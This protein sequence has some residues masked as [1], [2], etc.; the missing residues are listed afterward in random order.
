VVCSRKLKEIDLLEKG[1]YFTPLY[2]QSEDIPNSCGGEG[3]AGSP[4]SQ[5]PILMECEGSPS[6]TEVG[7]D[8]VRL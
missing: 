6:T 7:I 1:E 5:P 4:P 8:E 3:V 2:N